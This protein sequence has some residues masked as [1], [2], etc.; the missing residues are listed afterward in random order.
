MND[1]QHTSHSNK[2]IYQIKTGDAAIVLNSIKQA[3]SKDIGAVKQ[4]VSSEG[5]RGCRVRFRAD[6][7]TKESGGTGLW[8]TASHQ[9]WH[10]T[11]GMYDRLITGTS[12]WQPIELVIDVPKDTT[13]LS[14]GLWMQGNGTSKMRNPK[15]EVV[16]ETVPVTTI[17][18]WDRVSSNEWIERT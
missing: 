4:T 17:K 16:E 13:Y 6:L 11:D 9:D 1:W 7:S 15:F 3:S 10:I 14:F 2:Q 12:D 8:L 18:V 5:Y